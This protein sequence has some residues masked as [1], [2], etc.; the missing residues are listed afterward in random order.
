MQA[1]WRAGQSSGA[2]ITRGPRA[3]PQLLRTVGASRGVIHEAVCL[4]I[5]AVAGDAVRPRAPK[6]FYLALWQGLLR[7]GAARGSTA[8]VAATAA[9]AAAVSKEAA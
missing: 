2:C 3:R 4:L 8:A 6:R 1:G 7:C 5:V 9:A